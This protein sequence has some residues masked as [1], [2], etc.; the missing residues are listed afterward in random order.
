MTNMTLSINDSVGN[1]KNLHGFTYAKIESDIFPGKTTPNLY[2]LT[3][4]TK[5][6]SG[7]SVTYNVRLD[8]FTSFKTEF[9]GALEGQT[10][11]VKRM[12]EDRWVKDGNS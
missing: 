5:V 8:V 1:A 3:N 11:N 12:H 2:F 7:K 9:F 10:V 6:N 4:V